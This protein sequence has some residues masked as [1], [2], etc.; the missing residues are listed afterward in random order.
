MDRQLE[1]FPVNLLQSVFLFGSHTSQLQF[2]ATGRLEEEGRQAGGG[3]TG[4]RR[5]DRRQEMGQETGRRMGDRKEE[6]GQE[7]GWETGRR[8]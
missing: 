2:L 8:R 5:G 7:G 6:M 1:A 4:R 3:E